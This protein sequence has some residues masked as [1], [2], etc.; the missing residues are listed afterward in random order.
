[1]IYYKKKTIATRLSP[2]Y[3]R[4]QV[5]FDFKFLFKIHLIY[6]ETY[7]NNIWRWVCS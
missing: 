4:A 2:L 7:Y 5:D 1:M 3:W 6:V